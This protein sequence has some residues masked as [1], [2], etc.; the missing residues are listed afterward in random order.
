MGPTLKNLKK[1]LRMPTGCG[2][3][4]MTSL[5]PDVFVYNYLRKTGQLTQALESRILEYVMKGYYIIVFFTSVNM[6][7]SSK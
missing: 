6:F 3:Q 2:E 4:T 5:A 1:L 7:S